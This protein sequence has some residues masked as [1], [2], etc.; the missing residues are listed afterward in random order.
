M[1]QS[2]IELA[3][4]FAML[5]ILC[6]HI[7]YTTFGTPTSDE[8]Y[9]LRIIA[10]TLCIVGV[11]TY[12]LISGWF[13]IKP[14]AKSFIS[15]LYQVFFFSI[16]CIILSYA[17]NGINLIVCLKNLYIGAPYWFVIS[18][19][20]LYIVSPILN[21]F[22]ESTNSIQLGKTILFFGIFQLLY[23]FFYELAGFK[24]GYSLMSF[25]ELYLIARFIK[26]YK[27]KIQNWSALS[28][29]GMYLLFA[30][31]SAFIL[32]YYTYTDSKYII[33]IQGKILSYNSPLVILSSV[34]FFL[35][36]TKIKFSSK[37]VNKIAVSC[38]SVYLLHA[39]EFTLPIYSKYA[40]EISNATSYVP[41]LFL[42]IL[43]C[44]SVFILAC[45][46]DRIRLFSW[47]IIGSFI[48]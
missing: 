12:V 29:F 19:I 2:N 44:I 26:I 23:G 10:E 22:V 17:V 43:Y 20:G 41:A 31:I 32:L 21:A 7:N 28:N 47:K 11:N 24:S 37:Y 15:L 6:L 1:R 4:I 39:N 48:K 35:T 3:R 9:L 45:I 25:C 13:G 33:S 5:L 34:F 42:F 14:K 8:P 18:Y 16:I 40:I 27:T 38:F 36:F 30:F 46:I